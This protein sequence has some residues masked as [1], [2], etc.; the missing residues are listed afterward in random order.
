MYDKIIATT[1]LSCRSESEEAF[2]AEIL[3]QSQSGLGQL[4]RMSCTNFFFTVVP[5][6]VWVPSAPR[7]LG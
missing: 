7:P 6:C 5:K 2:A 1:L 4:Q 3:S